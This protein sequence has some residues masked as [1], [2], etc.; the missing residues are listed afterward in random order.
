MINLFHAMEQQLV[1]SDLQAFVDA[2]FSLAGR[3][4]VFCISES[5]HTERNKAASQNKSGNDRSRN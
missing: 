5:I 2:Q 4:G 3:T 1:K